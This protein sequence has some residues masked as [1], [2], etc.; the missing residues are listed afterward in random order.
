MVELF[1]VLCMVCVFLSLFTSVLLV[2]VP[3]VLWFFFKVHLQ[4]Q[5][6]KHVTIYRIN[7]AATAG[8]FIIYLVIFVMFGIFSFGVGFIFLVFLI[9][10]VVLLFQL[11]KTRPNISSSSD[12]SDDG[13]EIQVEMEVPECSKEIAQDC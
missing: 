13:L 9:P 7:L 10:F 6:E 12:Y 5:T 11:T 1:Y 8:V 3:M 2:L 4:K